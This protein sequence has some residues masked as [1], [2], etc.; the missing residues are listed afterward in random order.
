MH[1]PVFNGSIEIY[2][3]WMKDDY[4][5]NPSKIMKKWSP[6]A[7]NIFTDFNL[8]KFNYEDR[9]MI[10]FYMEWMQNY[11]DSSKLSKLPENVHTFM[12]LILE[13]INSPSMNFPIVNKVYN[14][15]LNKIR[16]EVEKGGEHVIMDELTYDKKPFLTHLYPT[17]FLEAIGMKG[18]VRE[19]K[20]NDILDDADTTQ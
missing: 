2:G 5:N 20:L 8:E 12:D 3:D 17:N 14:P 16:Y 7:D 10:L 18:Y 4:E 13:Y 11:D 6:V 19:Q 9:K 15:I 1:K